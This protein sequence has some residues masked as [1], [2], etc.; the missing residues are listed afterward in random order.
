MVVLVKAVY[1][2]AWALFKTNLIIIEY[3]MLSYSLL[4]KCDYPSLVK[5]YYSK[6][7]RQEHSI[8]IQ[9]K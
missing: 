6:L 9:A 3:D 5:T 1:S 7:G 2:E 8:E 4:G